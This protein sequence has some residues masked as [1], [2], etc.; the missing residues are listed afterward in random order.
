MPAQLQDALNL[1]PE[2]RKQL[3]DLQTEVDAKLAKILTDEQKARVA[4]MR[5][6]RA[7]GGGGPGGGPGGG[8]PG[9]GG[10]NGGGGGGG[11]RGDAG[12]PGRPGG[13]G[14]R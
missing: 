3:A 12:G 1:T 4:E 9:G 7:G 8:G 6:R 2:Q 13:G 11:G 10:R 5:A 14:D